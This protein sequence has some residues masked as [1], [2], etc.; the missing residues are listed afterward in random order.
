MMQVYS[1]RFTNPD[2]DQI[3]VSSDLGDF[4][5]SWPCQTWHRQALLAWLDAGNT[6][7]P[8]LPE[9]DV[10]KARHA[11][12]QEVY[13]RAVNILDA[14]TADYAVVEQIIWPDLEREA[15]RFM[16]DGSLGPLMQAELDTASRSAEELAYAIVHRAKRLTRFRG[17]VISARAA[18]VKRINGM[19]LGALESYDITQGWPDPQDL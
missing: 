4:Y 16:M 2:K 5:L 3:E 10:A 18:H 9:S 13:R 17:A 19:E 1:V 8:F 7:K 12:I 11:L 6:I 14:A 15:R